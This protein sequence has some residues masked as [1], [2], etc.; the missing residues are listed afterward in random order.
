MFVQSD[1]SLDRSE[2]GLGVG[3]T[4]VKRLVEMH[5]GTVKAYSEGT[6][7]GSEFVIQLPIMGTPIAKTSAPRRQHAPKAVSYRV[8]VVDDNVDSATSLATILRVTGNDVRTAHDGFEAVEV[9]S[10]F[11]PQLILLDIG[12][13]KLNGYDTC[14]RIREEPWGKDIVVVALTGWGNEEDKRRSF[15]AGFNSHL[16]KPIGIADLQ[17][18]LSQMESA[19]S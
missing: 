7:K 1:R 19:L 9:A 14:R 17:S 18:L 16:V 12:M 8:L 10:E 2:G 6:D 5:G 15:D 11:G 13:P 4:I 3:L